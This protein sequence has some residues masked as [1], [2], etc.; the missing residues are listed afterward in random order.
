MTG[1]IG[2]TLTVNN[3]PD[4]ALRRTYMVIR[5]VDNELWFYDAW[6]RDD[7]EKAVRQ[8]IEEHCM[9]IPVSVVE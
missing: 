1:M 3:V 4:W 7:G 6:D 9:V 8:A 5:P 2:N